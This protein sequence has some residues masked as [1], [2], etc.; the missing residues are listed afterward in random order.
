MLLR[1]INTKS[2]IDGEKKQLAEL[3]IQSCIE[4]TII[5]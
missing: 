2:K 1:A 3:S 5:R 4:I